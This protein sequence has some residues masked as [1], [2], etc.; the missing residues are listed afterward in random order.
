MTDR[1]ITDRK[2]TLIKDIPVAERPREKLLRYGAASLSNTE[3]IA[4]LL[5]SGTQDASAITLAERII[6]ADPQG[7]LFLRDC[8]PEELC[9]I[10]GIGPAK[11]AVIIAAAELG[12]RL[13]T[14]PV[15]NRINIHSVEDVVSLFM[16][17]M[18]HLKKEF[19]KVL[20]LN[21]KNKII[22]VDEV[23]A[24]SLM[25]TE[26]HPR[27]VFSNP[28]RRG[29]ASIILIHNHPS[30]DPS[31]SKAD[32][33]ITHKLVMTGEIIGIPVL[34]HVIIGDGRYVSLKAEGYLEGSDEYSEQDLQ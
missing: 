11:S 14:T 19:F 32:I 18:R 6:S 29:A 26:V 22:M 34:D 10:D 27:E 3:L 33:F 9:S 2:I 21:A 7:V 5:G 13:A 12:R 15:E 30:G 25:A 17:S 28:I 31:P 1:K 16:D 20:L 24:G 4:L 23:S 8:T